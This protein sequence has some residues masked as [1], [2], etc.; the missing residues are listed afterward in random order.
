MYG[1]HECFAINAA[2]CA[3]VPHHLKR[4]SEM[5]LMSLCLMASVNFSQLCEKYLLRAYRHA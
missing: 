1:V 3:I 5:P 4:S 2:D